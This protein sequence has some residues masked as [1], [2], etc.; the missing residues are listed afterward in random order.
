MINLLKGFYKNS[1]QE[2]EETF[3]IFNK[4][5]EYQDE[6]PK[7]IEKNLEIEEFLVFKKY[8]NYQSFD[9]KLNEIFN[10]FSYLKGF[11]IQHQKFII[12]LY[13]L[14]NNEKKYEI[15]KKMT[16]CL[17]EKYFDIWPI[18]YQQVLNIVR[19]PEF[20]NIIQRVLVTNKISNKIK[21]MTIEKLQIILVK[22]K[23]KFNLIKSFKTF[24]DHI[25][26]PD[27]IIEYLISYLQYDINSEMYK[28]IMFILCIYFSIK[29]KQEEYFNILIAIISDT[30]L[31]KFIV[32]NIKSVTDPKEIF[33]LY[34][35]LN[36]VNFNMNSKN[37]KEVLQIPINIIEN[38]VIQNYNPNFNMNMFHENLEY[39]NQHYKCGIFN[40]KRDKILRK[41]FFNY[42]NNSP[43]L[44]LY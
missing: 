1:E 39:F 34:G 31:Y 36:Y 25:E 19:S 14:S 18:I 43:N 30:K 12:H 21:E 32:D 27:K 8:K 2:I 16:E 23:N 3:N 26:V 40:P 7:I 6:F 10:D 20:I 38:I 44:L 35:C 24:F 17:T 29:V 42:E 13:K 33:Y 4:I 9:N 41:Y 28:E 15:L 11:S 37:E 22:T 5:K